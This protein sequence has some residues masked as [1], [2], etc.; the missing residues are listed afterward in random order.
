MSEAEQPERNYYCIHC[1]ELVSARWTQ[2]GEGF[3]GN[4]TIKCGCTSV[5]FV[6]QM[7]Q[8][9][10]PDNWRVRRPDCCHDVDVSTLETDYGSGVADYE[11]P[12][13]GST[14]RYDGRLSSGPQRSPSELEIDDDQQTLHQ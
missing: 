6:P 5:P 1:E 10:V 4:I 3:P 12:E 13:C 8:A 7:S 2:A 11:C 9:E 14:Y